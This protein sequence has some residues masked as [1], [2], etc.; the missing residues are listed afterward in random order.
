MEF[1]EKSLE[2]VVASRSFEKT[3]SGTL[4]Q[5]LSKIIRGVLDLS[6]GCWALSLLRALPYLF[7][8]HLFGW[9]LSR[10]AL[11]LAGESRYNNP[12]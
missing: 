2:V 3:L 11:S 1:G 5:T 7:D 4:L 6:V 10:I 8:P 9:A 12:R